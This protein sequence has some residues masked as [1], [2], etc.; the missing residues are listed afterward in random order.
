MQLCQAPGIGAQ[1]WVLPTMPNPLYYV[2]DPAVPGG[3]RLVTDPQATGTLTTE[4]VQ[5]A[6]SQMLN[7]VGLSYN[8][9]ANAFRTSSAQGSV[10]VSDGSGGAQWATRQSSS[11][12][13][14]ASITET[15][16]A[17]VAPPVLADFNVIITAGST[18]NRSV[19][20]HVTHQQRISNMAP[21]EAWEAN[22]TATLSGSYS[23]VEGQ[24]K[25]SSGFGKKAAP[26]ATDTFLVQEGFSIG[27]VVP[28]GQTANVRIVGTLECPAGFV[29]GSRVYTY[30]GSHAARGIWFDV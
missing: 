25:M 21:N 5:D 13:Q 14:A 12:A 17:I 16:A 1:P 28:K 4:D 23:S 3:Y 9:D 22:T 8:D 6:V 10:L 24:Y 2:A 30:G 26:A 29:G 19:L 15:S 7:N 11:I 18:F 27:F 20:L